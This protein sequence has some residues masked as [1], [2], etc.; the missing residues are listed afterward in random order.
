M[1]NG[2][3]GQDNVHAHERVNSQSIS[4]RCE[5]ISTDG[6]VAT[7]AD[8]GTRPMRKRPPSRTQRQLQVPKPQ[9]RAKGCYVGVFVEAYALE[10]LQIDDH[11]AVLAARAIRPVRVAPGAGLHLELVLGRAEH[12]VGDVLVAGGDD[13]RGWLVLETEVVG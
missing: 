6:K 11:G 12:G 13:D 7:S 2:A 5:A 3:I 9:A 1:H 4:P 8:I 10:L